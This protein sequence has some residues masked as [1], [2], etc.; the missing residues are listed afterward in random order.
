M[1][2]LVVVVVVVVV[3][4][5]L[6]GKMQLI[7]RAHERYLRAGIKWVVA[8]VKIMRSLNILHWD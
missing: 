3:V 4:V 6:R 2:E 7:S 8:Q 1:V 5:E